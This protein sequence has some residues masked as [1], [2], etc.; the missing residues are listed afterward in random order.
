MLI[1][2]QIDVLMKTVVHLVS[3]LEICITLSNISSNYSS[4][5]GKVEKHGKVYRERVVTTI[6]QTKISS[7]HSELLRP[8]QIY[9]L[10]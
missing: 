2:E 8:S 6:R 1:I 3:F 10:F 4:V 5:G 7:E 9:A